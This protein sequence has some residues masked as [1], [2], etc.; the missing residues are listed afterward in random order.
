MRSV[1]RPRPSG[2]HPVRLVVTDDLA[3]LA[4]HRPLPAAARDPASRLGRR[5]GGLP[6]SRSPSSC[7]SRSWSRGGRRARCTTSSPSYVRYSAQVRRVPVP[8]RRPVPGFT[9]GTPTRSTSRSTRRGVQRP[10]RRRASGSCSRS[11]RLLLSLV[12]RRRPARERSGRSAR[13]RLSP[14]GVGGARR[15]G[16]RSSA[17]S[18]ALARGRMPHGLR[19]LRHV[20]DRLRRRRRPRTLLLVTDRYPDGDPD[21]VSPTP[22]LP[23][24]PGRDRGRPTTLRRSRLTVFFRVLLAVPHLLWLTL[25]SVLVALAALVGLA[26]RA[27]SSAGCPRPLHRFLAAFV[28]Y[29]D[30]RRTRSSSSSA[31]RSPGFVGARGQLPRRPR[32]SSR[33]E[34]Q[35]RAGDAVPARARV[36]R[37]RRSRARTAARSPSSPCSAGGCARH[38]PHAGGDPEP[39]RRRPPLQ[40]PGERLP[41]SCSPTATYAT[42][43]APALTPGRAPS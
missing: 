23:P 32:R 7:G 36:P 3:P 24:A 10:A 25:W 19:D 43:V 30:A 22:A 1:E 27:R 34:R 16:R 39:R 26:R 20:R 6:P 11:P 21:A 15:G 38:R 8:R 12:A 9:G 28:R 35:R 5:C 31:A 42:P 41:A 40:R 37:A 4:A 29:V 14:T 33:R 13:R 17:G 18:P 2:A